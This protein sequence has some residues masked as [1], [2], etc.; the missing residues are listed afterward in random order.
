LLLTTGDVFATK[1][2]LGHADI[3]TTANIYVQGNEP[4]LES[5]MREAFGE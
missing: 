3:S 5:K 2:L 1:D 4:S